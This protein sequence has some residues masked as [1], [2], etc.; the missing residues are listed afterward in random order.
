M[1]K[2]I[3]KEPL[4][5]TEVEGVKLGSVGNRIIAELPGGR[6]V[7]RSVDRVLKKG[8][9]IELEDGTRL[10]TGK[11]PTNP[12]VTAG[13]PFLGECFASGISDFAG[14]RPDPRVACDIVNS[15]PAR[16]KP[17]TD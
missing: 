9:R 15:D 16:N 10:S 14:V 1:T 3:S 11:D 8:H 17:R 5:W 13:V 4:Y 2:K 6:K 7:T 12:H